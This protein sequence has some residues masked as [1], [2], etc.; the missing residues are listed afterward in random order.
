MGLRAIF[1]DAGNTLV[2]ADRERTLAPLK[3]RGVEV[4][5][6]TIFAAERAARRFRDANAANDPQHTDQQYWDTY[7]QELLSHLP[8]HLDLLPELVAAAR[9]SGN[10]RMVSPGTRDCLLRLRERYRLG[11]ISNSDGH[12]GDLFVRVG[13]ADC[14][15][16]ITDS[17]KV[18]FQK[19]H[20]EI[21]RAAL[22]SLAVAPEESIYIGDV[23]SIDYTGARAAGMQAMLMDPF[24]T[25]ADEGVPRA[26]NL[27]EVEALLG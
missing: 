12:I 8:A 13:L 16:T 22:R 1:F 3:S 19:P 15:E 18:G 10:W 5:E 9:N 6:E 2:F 20:P 14:F 7:Y 4:A 23:Y 21:F 25:Y 26:T 17:G 11:V 24:G 27:K